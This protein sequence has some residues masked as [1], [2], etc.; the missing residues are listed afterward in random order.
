MVRA[1]RLMSLVLLLQGRGGMTAG[2]LAQEL[3]VSERTIHR[4]VL[5]LSEAGIPVYADR[6]RTGGYRL[7]DGYRTRLTGLDRAEAEALF[8]SGVP[9]ALR[10]MGLREIAEAA[11]LKAAAALAPGLR[12]APATAA[13]RFHLDAP[14]W[15]ASDT[16]PP[17]SLA[18]LARA[19]WGNHPVSGRYREAPRA[20]EPYGLVLKAGVWYLAGRAK[21]RLLVYRVDRFTEVSV[22]TAR[23]F[24]RDPAFDLAAFWAERSEQFTRSLL[25]TQ[26]TL[27]LSPAGLR[28][29]RHVA[30]PAAL[31]EALAS[32]RDDGTVVLAVES[33]AVAYTQVLAFG[34]E[35]EVLDPPE[36]RALVAE[37]AARMSGLYAEDARGG[38]PR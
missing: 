15:F 10:D 11:R 29:L 9:D 6:G 37:A 1:A 20:V 25:R 24:D 31:P 26:V 35:A 13:Q 17:E 38:G 33:P 36:L 19:V 30:D 12:D 16:P 23:R 4:D 34:P 3:E 32:A 14:G 18:P 8:L 7:V 22:D 27:R 21:E 5:A 2:E 28:M